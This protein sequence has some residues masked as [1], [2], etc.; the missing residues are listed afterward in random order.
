MD[1]ETSRP[2]L[3]EAR[4]AHA[5]GDPLRERVKCPRDSDWCDGRICVERGI[6]CPNADGGELTL[7]EEVKLDRDLEARDELAAERAG[8][9]DQ[10][11]PSLPPEWA[12]R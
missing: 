12:T 10:L 8:R 2:Q 5:H 4:R 3:D 6:W 11:E 1:A 7:D 9:F